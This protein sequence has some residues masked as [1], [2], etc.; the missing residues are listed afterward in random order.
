MVIYMPMESKLFDF[1][2]ETKTITERWFQEEGGEGK[3][4]TI[5]LK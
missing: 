2:T 3:N 5:K 4:L 1:Y